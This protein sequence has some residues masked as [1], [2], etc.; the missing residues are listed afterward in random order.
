MS[1]IISILNQKGGVGKS[2][3][4]T[5]LANIFHFHFDFKIAV[6]DCDF[7]QHTI[8]KKRQRELK[9]I[10]NSI[11]LKPSTFISKT[12]KTISLLLTL[13]R[14]RVTSHGSLSSVS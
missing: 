12:N 13:R 6:I 8:A 10:E 11:H 7:P 4:T 5:L 1:K 2:N 3:V 14:N 9:V